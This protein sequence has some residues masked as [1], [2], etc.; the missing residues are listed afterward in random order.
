MDGHIIIGTELDTK[1]F[2]SQIT[3]IEK[4]MEEIEDKLKKADMGFEVGDTIKL[5]AQYE[6]LSNRL[7]E[8]IRKKEELNKKDLSKMQKS[9]E[10]VG[11]S[12]SGVIKKMGK[13]AL[14]VFGIRSAY[15]FVRQAMSTLSQ[16]NDQMATDVEY[17]RYLLAS[18]LQPVIETLI[19]LAYKLLTYINFIAKAWF[20]VDLFANASADAFNKNK[21][22][23]AGASKNAK[24]LQK[25]LTGFDKVNILQDNGQTSSG[26]GGGGVSMPS[27]PTPEDVPIP[28]W[29]QWIADNGELVIAILGGIA[30]GL[31]AIHFGAS[32]IM[33]LG[34]GIAI[35]GLIILVQSIIDFI[36]DPSWENFANILKGL[37]IL[38]TGVAIAMIAV[39]A[40]NPVAWILLA[41]A[42]IAALVALIIE[43]WDKIKEVLGKVGAWIYDHI[44][45]PVGDFFKGLWD[46]IVNGFNAAIEWIKTTFN[47]VVNFFKGIINT[48]VTLFKN[49]G[50]KVGNVIGGAFKGVINGVL[51][52]IENILNFPIRSI[53]GLIG[54][55]NAIPGINLG[56]LSTFKLPRLAKGGILN[57]PGRGVDYYGANIAERGPEGVVPLTNKESLETIGRTIAK[58]TKFDANVTLE[59]EGRILARVMEEINAN[60][61]FARNGG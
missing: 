13:W 19:Q 30:A 28:S 41:I 46:G 60:R 26:G 50:T 1:D 8:L 11:D 14:A 15:M 35:A 25:T 45:K 9:I 21:Q 40:A 3:Y 38:L 5:E 12:V 39:N 57:M 34:I 52:A 31:L 58:Y 6:K 4:Q 42:L 51:S 18:T 37:A 17:I 32:L 7:S 54:V 61:S 29:V 27:F 16:Y 24:E 44:I 56:K 48:I 49:I 47:N 43:N 2:D 22:A 10:G 59:L 53:N 55:I 36:N 33:G 20:G 23:L